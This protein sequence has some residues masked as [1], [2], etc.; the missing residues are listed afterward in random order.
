MK[1]N[2]GMLNNRLK[3]DSHQHFWQLSRNDYPWLTPDL[4]VL[5]QDFLPE[6]LTEEL[7]VS[8]VSETI[9]VQAAE[10]EAE[11]QFL[12][13][14]ANTTEFV[15]GVVG[16]VDMESPEVINQLKAFA[17]NAYFK[18]IRPMLQDLSDV[19]WILDDKYSPIFEYLSANHL[20]FDALIRTQ[21]L[22]HIYALGKRYP[23]LKIVIN[24]C[25]KPDVNARLPSAWET[26]ISQFKGV[27][28]VFVKL[29]GL[30]TEA[31]NEDV[32][33]EQLAPYFNHI[34]ATFGA[35]R[36]MWGS[37]WP[38]LKLNGSYSTWCHLSEA[39]LSECNSNEQQ[40]IWAN[41][42]RVFYRLSSV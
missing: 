38:V 15:S 24:H 29:S 16:W 17:K 26:Q 4:K 32:S 22:S 11:T 25:A 12:L 37:D 23:T 2:N 9:L 28:N 18:G 39:L 31:A 3:I 33:K 14:L 36:I 13:E 8:N 34:L 1:T 19:S 5:Y 35:T 6:N 7:S 41:N 20:S 30:V 40:N 27:N 42:A 21:H 10:S